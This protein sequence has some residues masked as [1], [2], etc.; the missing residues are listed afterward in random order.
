MNTVKITHILWR[1]PQSIEVLLSKLTTGDNI[2]D[3]T[4]KDVSGNRL[5]P[6]FILNRERAEAIYGIVKVQKNKTSDGFRIPTLD[7]TEGKFQ[8]A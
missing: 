6:K 7:I 1:R 8:Y 4:V 2:I 3:I 5:F